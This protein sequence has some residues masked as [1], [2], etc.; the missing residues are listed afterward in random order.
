LQSKFIKAIY[1]IKIKK[2]KKNKKNPVGNFLFEGILRGQILK[3]VYSYFSEN[4]MLCF[5]TQ[6]IFLENQRQSKI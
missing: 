1:I 3:K 4:T 6:C 5:F 2:I